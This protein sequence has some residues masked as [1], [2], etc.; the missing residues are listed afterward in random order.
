MA[1]TASD[2]GTRN[3]GIE[4]EGCSLEH[5]WD[6]DYDGLIPDPQN[7]M[8]FMAFPRAKITNEEMCQQH[9]SLNIWE[10]I[11]MIDL[12]TW[13]VSYEWPDLETNYCTIQ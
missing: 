11:I 12:D 4:L 7:Q 10:R 9:W 5:P 3:W 2:E 13:I 1:L 6:W 8:V